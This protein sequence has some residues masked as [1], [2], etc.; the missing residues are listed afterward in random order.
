MVVQKEVSQG[1]KALILRIEGREALRFYTYSEQR[2]GVVAKRLEQLLGDHW[3]NK[4]EAG[5][6][7]GVLTLVSDGVALVG[8]DAK[9]AK[10]RQLSLEALAQLWVKSLKKAATAPTL[11]LSKPSLLVPV[12][13]FREVSFEG[14]AQGPANITG[15]VPTIALC[16]VEGSVLT[17]FGVSPGKFEVRLERDFVYTTLS[18]TVKHYAAT[19]LRPEG[20]VITGSPFPLSLLRSFLVKRAQESVLLRPRAKL[21]VLQVEPKPPLQPGEEGFFTVTVKAEGRDW[22]PIVKPLKIPVSNEMLPPSHPS[23]YLLS[24][25][26]EE[27][28]QPGILSSLVLEQ[29]NPLRM[30]I[31]HKNIADRPLEFWLELRNPSRDP[32]RVHFVEA[33]GGPDDN[34]LFAGYRATERFFQYF[35]HQVGRVF[36]LSGDEVQRVVVQRLAP[37]Q[38]LSLMGYLQLLQ[39]ELLQVRFGFSELKGNHLLRP[40]AL[41]PSPRWGVYRDEIVKKKVS[42]EVGKRWGFLD[43]GI[44]EVHDISSTQV[45]SGN[46]GLMVEIAVHAKN[47]TTRRAKVE[48]LLDAAAGSCAGVFRVEGDWV[49]IPYLR[50]H[51]ERQIT[52]FSLSPGKEQTITLHTIPVPGAHYPARIVVRGR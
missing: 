22:I 45:L 40:F 9:E 30:L 24:N 29:R 3:L 26:P 20:L 35:V 8:I 51:R 37:Q 16:V 31:H 14:T 42:Y 33:F 4:V 43:L 50:T 36:E 18:V 23:L 25:E 39:G 2:V 6:V 7:H 46:Y 15:C 12:G 38:T 1:A 44:E 28:S 32:A 34:A 13:E 19:F 17:V 48:V 41:L 49:T 5:K 11:Y 52:S 21:R 27:V 10:A 47:P